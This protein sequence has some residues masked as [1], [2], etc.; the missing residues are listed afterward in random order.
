MTINLKFLLTT[1]AIAAIMFACMFYPSDISITIAS[2]TRVFAV[3]AA[4]L[5]VIRDW[6]SPNRLL[7]G[8]VVSSIV[9]YSTLERS[10]YAETM[11]YN[12]FLA[13]HDS[14]AGAAPFKGFDKY[15]RIASQAFHLLFCLAFGIVMAFA[16]PTKKASSTSP[17]TRSPAASEPSEAASADQGHPRERSDNRTL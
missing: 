4:T 14:D 10:D 3:S 15:A 12:T 17:R 11:Y 8:F 6:P 16:A 13:I 5:V 7:L 1:V 9:I 2:L